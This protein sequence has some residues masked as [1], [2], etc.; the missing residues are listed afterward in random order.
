MS[1]SF[2]KLLTP[3]EVSE[4][5]KVTV[6]TLAV[7]RSTKRYPLAYIKTGRA[8]RYPAVE[9]EKFLKRRTVSQ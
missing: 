7:W 5:L 8:V 9:V 6:G 2:P 3:Q 4:I 1:I